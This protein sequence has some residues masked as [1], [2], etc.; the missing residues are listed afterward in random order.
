[1]LT[2]HGS[3]EL[4]QPEQTRERAAFRRGPRRLELRVGAAAVTTTLHQHPQVRI[5]KLIE[6]HGNRASS[7]E[8]CRYRGTEWRPS[9]I[10]S[11]G[12]DHR[13]ERT[14]C[15]RPETIQSEDRG[16]VPGRGQC[17][18]SPESRSGEP[19]RE[20]TLLADISPPSG[21]RQCRD[22]RPCGRTHSGRSWSGTCRPHPPSWPLPLPRAGSQHSGAN[23]AILIYCRLLVWVVVPVF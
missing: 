7:A 22:A 19:R 18:R 23:S 5:H 16:T 11:S 17:L 3:L 6:M 10:G 2:C 15:Q 4:S 1:M 9:D 21:R 12:G 13:T 14:L 8:K 20:D